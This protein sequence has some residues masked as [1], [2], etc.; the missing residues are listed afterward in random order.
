MRLGFRNRNTG[1]KKKKAPLSRGFF[2]L[3]QP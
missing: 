2:V 1:T 3:P